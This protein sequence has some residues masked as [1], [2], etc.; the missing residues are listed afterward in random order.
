MLSQGGVFLSMVSICPW[1]WHVIAAHLP[2]LLACSKH[3]SANDTLLL[4]V[5]SFSCSLTYCPLFP[6][7]VCTFWVLL[8]IFPC[9]PSCSPVARDAHLPAVCSSVGNPLMRWY[10]L[11]VGACPLNTL[12]LWIQ[13]GPW[14]PNAIGTLLSLGP[15]PPLFLSTFGATHTGCIFITAIQALGSLCFREFSAGRLYNTP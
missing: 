15:L 4:L 3:P 2:L 8:P 12:E 7:L 13:S 10:I 1:W 6:S 5:P 11:L 9:C 14:H